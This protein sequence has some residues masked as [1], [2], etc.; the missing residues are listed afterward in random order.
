M[1]IPNQLTVFRVILLQFFILLALVNF[2]LG[3]FPFLGF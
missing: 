3:K 2:G 1:N